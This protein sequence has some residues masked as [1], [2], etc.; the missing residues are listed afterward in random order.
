MAI[1]TF[2]EREGE[3]RGK[4]IQDMTERKRRK[5]KTGKEKDKVRERGRTR[6]ER[7][8]TKCGKTGQ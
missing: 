3:K 8:Q 5:K 7:N 1:N 6:N 4:S 2:R